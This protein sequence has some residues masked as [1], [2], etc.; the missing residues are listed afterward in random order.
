MVLLVLFALLLVVWLV[1]PKVQEDV[2]RLSYPQKYSD[3]VK[4]QAA[5]FSLD[6]SLVYAVIK[7]ESN[8]D[9]EAESPVGALGLM[10]MMPETFTWM[11]THIGGDYGAEKLFEPEISIR[12]GCALLRLLL[13]SYGEDLSVVLSAYNAGMGNVTSWLSDTSYSEDGK[14]LT[15]IPFD[16]TRLYVEK[17]IRYKEI[18][19]K[20]YGGNGNG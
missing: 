1:R 19:E 3:L 16:E 12:Y 18:Y 11:Q 2:D 5:E 10:Q 14:T 17:V 8:F 6:E 7:A 20:L 13:D 4:M 15:H 9:A